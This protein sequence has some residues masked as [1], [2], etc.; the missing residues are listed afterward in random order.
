M[1]MVELFL[2]GLGVLIFYSVLIEAHQCFLQSELQVSELICQKFLYC[3]QQD[4]WGEGTVT[5]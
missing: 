1:E 2:S 4:K 5:I 3:W